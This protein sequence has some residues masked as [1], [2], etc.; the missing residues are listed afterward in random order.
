MTLKLKMYMRMAYTS[1]AN[2]TEVMALIN[3]DN[4]ITTDAKMVQFVD[5]QNRRSPWY[6]IEVDRLGDVNQRASNTMMKYLEFNQ[7]PR[8]DGI[9][10]PGASGHQA[11]EQGDFANRDIPNAELSSMSKLLYHK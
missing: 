4:F 3:A 1:M 11:K 7:D 2:G 6:E 10:N 9:Y 8:I 5:E